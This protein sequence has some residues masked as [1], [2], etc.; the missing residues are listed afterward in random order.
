MRHESLVQAGQLAD[1]SIIDQYG[2]GF[3]RL[4]LVVLDSALNPACC[5]NTVWLDTAYC[6]A[7]AAAASV[8]SAASALAATATQ[9]LYVGTSSGDLISFSSGLDSLA[10]RTLTDSSGQAVITGV[11][12]DSAG[13]VWVADAR[14][15]NVRS[16]DPQGTVQDTIGNPAQLLTPGSV[17]VA[18]NGAVW[19]ADRA[20]NVIR[21]YDASKS[22]RLSFGSSGSG[23]GQFSEPWAVALNQQQDRCYV[24]DAGNRRVQV[25]DTSG[26]YVASF[27]DSTLRFPVALSVD[28]NNCCFVADTGIRAVFGFDPQGNRF[29]TITSRDTMQPIAA[30]VSGDNGSLYTIDQSHH[31]LLAYT[32][33]YTDT[34]LFGGGQSGPSENL[35][36]RQVE[37]YPSYP[38][39]ATERASIRYGVP[40]PTRVT[41]GVCDI[42]GKLVA[43]L[44]NRETKAPGFYTATWNCRDKRNRPV[45][46]G[47]YFYRLMAENEITGG[48]RSVK[49]QARTRKLVIAR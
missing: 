26:G 13:N 8:N 33:L 23:P 11:A 46:A 36:P 1:R 27:G 31:A 12:A 38:N 35:R 5:E 18:R 20:G 21:V 17:F 47:V 14:D 45:A 4:R 42:S 43:V 19:V 25:F 32:V 28:A 40:R 2:T 41:L 7:T 10:A 48:K 29:V 39:P 22:L 37:L 16:Y 30:A 34:S 24:A 9:G 49:T 6:A 15:Q 44:L 3:Y